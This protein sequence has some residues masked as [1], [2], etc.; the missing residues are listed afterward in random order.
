MA[1]TSASSELT[2]E[3]LHALLEGFVKDQRPCETALEKLA[4]G[5]PAG[6]EQA[7]L[8][9]LRKGGEGPAEVLLIKLL[10]QIGLL[11]ELL[12]DPERVP[13]DEAISLAK[14]S[15]RNGLFLDI[16]LAKALQH[17]PSPQRTDRVLRLLAEIAESNRILPLLFP[18]LRAQQKRVRSK[19]ALIFAKVCPSCT[20]VKNALADPDSRVRANAVEALW[21]GKSVRSE[22][23]VALKDPDN[24]V[25]ANAAL[26]LYKLGDPAGLGALEEMARCSEDPFRASAAWAMGETGE[27]DL[28]PALKPLT[29]DSEPLVSRNALRAI[30][31]IQN[32]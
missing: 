4:V 24:R 3:S 15:S 27:Q 26:G 32:C 25:R 14:L 22:L 16:S 19:A 31:K 9:Y 10:H 23:L 8:K 20:F 18:L 6:F 30:A 17:S 12:A 2:S 11:L 1:T 7:V 13:L 29:Q 5:N 21:G 28:L